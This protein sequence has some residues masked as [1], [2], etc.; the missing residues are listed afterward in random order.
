MIAEGKQRAKELEKMRALG[1]K[2]EGTEDSQSL[3]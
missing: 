2:D 3:S 1:I